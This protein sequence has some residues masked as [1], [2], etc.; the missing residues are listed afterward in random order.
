MPYGNRKQAEIVDL[1]NRMIAYLEAI[2]VKAILLAC[3][4]ISSNLR[5]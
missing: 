1:A 2:G 5:F 4:T 3:N